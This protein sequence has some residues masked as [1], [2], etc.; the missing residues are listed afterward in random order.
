MPCE[1]GMRQLISEGVKFDLIVTSPPYNIKD[2]HA[3]TIKY[4][5]YKGN[6]MNE[7]KY[8]Q[9]QIECLDLMFQLLKDDGSL[10][11]N[12][13]NRISEGRTISPMEWIIQTPFVIKQDITWNQKKGAN[14]DKCRCFPFSEKIYWLTKSSKV[15]LFNKHN[16][17]DVW[18]IV[19]KTNRKKM[20][21]PAI[22]ELEIAE[23]IYSF[24]EDKQDLLVLDP[25]AGIATSFIPIKDKYKYIGFEIDSEYIKT[26]EN[27]LESKVS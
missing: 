17:T 9:W 18:D 20:G 26:A 22:M 19:P 24:Y 2:F 15:K 13:K 27:R 7:Q 11:Y 5:N 12:H 6:N 10:W 4:E 14:V 23:T 1:E 21:H 8:Q 3:N 25:F 16:M